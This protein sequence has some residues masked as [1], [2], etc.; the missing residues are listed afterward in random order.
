MAIAYN[1]SIVRNGLVLHLDAA[2]RKSYPG[3]GTVCTDLSNGISYT[4]Q[5]G[6][7][8]STANNGTFVFDGTND[9]ILVPHRS[10]LNFGSSDFTIDV[11]FYLNS[12]TNQPRIIQKGLV[13][14]GNA[15]F[16]LILNSTQYFAFATNATGSGA[17]SSGSASDWIPLINTWY[18]AAIVK[19]ANTV[20]YYRNGIYFFQGTTVDNTLYSGTSNVTI[21]S[22]ISNGN[23]LNGYIP[24]IKVYNRAL[25]AA[26]IQQNFEALRGRYGI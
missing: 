14:N 25:S 6:T 22:T 15:E 5:N 23:V 17:F 10:S 11:F 20:S 9:N 21:G 1:T 19:V 4:L 12:L 26:E 24:N 18:H 16:L 13:A 7:G 3:S 8:Y 2:N